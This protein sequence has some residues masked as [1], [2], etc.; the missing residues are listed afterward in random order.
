MRALRWTFT[1]TASVT[2]GLAVFATAAFMMMAIAATVRSAS[3]PPVPQ[4]GEAVPDFALPDL[5]GNDVDLASFRGKPVV[6]VFWADWCPD[7]KPIIPELNRLHASG[8]HVLAINLMESKERVAAAVKKH[9]IQYPV[10]LDR[11]GDVGRLY[12]VTGIPNV[13]V[14]DENGMLKEHRYSAPE[15]F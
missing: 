13:F 3:V 10:V 1:I 9:G 11:N 15:D 8:V 14:V 7:C 6:L 12:G 4:V 5:T 2:V